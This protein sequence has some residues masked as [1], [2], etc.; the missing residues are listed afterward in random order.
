MKE[1]HPKAVRKASV[2]FSFEDNNKDIELKC[3]ASQI[4]GWSVSPSVQPCRV[5]TVA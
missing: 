4:N 3:D 2:Y 1:E 5:S